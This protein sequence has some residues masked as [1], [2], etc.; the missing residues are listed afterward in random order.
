MTANSDPH[1][2]EDF[3]DLPHSRN[4]VHNK[5]CSETVVAQAFM[6]MPNE[7]QNFKSASPRFNVHNS[8]PDN[9]P[10]PTPPDREPASQRTCTT[11]D[12]PDTPDTPSFARPLHLIDTSVLMC[13]D[14]RGDKWMQDISIYK[15][16]H[17]NDERVDNSLCEYCFRRRGL[18]SRLVTYGCELCGR[19]QRLESLYWESAVSPT[20]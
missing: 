12:R 5:T 4:P 16:T 15:S 14:G 1:L 6:G 8:A 2:T 17:G 3:Q 20:N 7:H 9:V 11:P 18:F 19:E 13:D 10:R